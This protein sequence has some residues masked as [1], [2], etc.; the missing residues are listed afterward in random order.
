M[1]CSCL[2]NFALPSPV[3]QH[4]PG[5]GA[6]ELPRAFYAAAD[7]PLVLGAANL[8]SLWASA[9]G[10]HR[11]PFQSVALEVRGG[12]CQRP[13]HDQPHVFHHVLLR[14]L[15]RR[16]R[17]HS[18]SGEGP[19]PPAL[20]RRAELLDFQL[21]GR[22]NLRSPKQHGYATCTAAARG[23][24]LGYVRRQAHAVAQRA[25][26]RGRARRDGAAVSS[27]APAGV[28]GGKAAHGDAGPSGTRHRD[29][30]QRHGPREPVPSGDH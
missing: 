27:E 9:M 2:G 25:A 30:P 19:H 22:R 12:G 1:V 18:D 15:H 6:L 16:A 13:I 29:A 20:A 21:G 8:P 4:A 5:G 26:R 3:H 10:A 24:R 7:M 17:V 14:R 11:C 23:A 28:P